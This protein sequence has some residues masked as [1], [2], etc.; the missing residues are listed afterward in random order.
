MVIGKHYQLRDNLININTHLFFHLF[1]FFVRKE[2]RFL[3]RHRFHVDQESVCD[4]WQT[5]RQIFHIAMVYR[6]LQSVSPHLHE[7]F[8]NHG[9]LQITRQR[10]VIKAIVAIVAIPLQSLKEL[11]ITISLLSETMNPSKRM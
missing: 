1:S 8:K 2:V 11:H 4:L 3:L 10:K 7:H 6:S 9:S 5:L